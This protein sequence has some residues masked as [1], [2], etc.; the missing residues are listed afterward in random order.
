M[1]NPKDE[2]PE[3]VTIPNNYYKGKD[4]FEK[5]KNGTPIRVGGIPIDE[6]VDMKSNV[7]RSN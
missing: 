3:W 7:R 1:L 6:L 4:L 2:L 5:D